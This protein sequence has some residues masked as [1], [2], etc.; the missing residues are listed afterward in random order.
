MADD[1]A[2]ARWKVLAQIENARARKNWGFAGRTGWP[3]DLG[4][5][6]PLSSKARAERSSQVLALS[7][8]GRSIPQIGREMGLANTTVWRILHGKVGR[9]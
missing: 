5:G 3:G 6:L 2:L 4:T 9:G 7:R 8:A 1:T